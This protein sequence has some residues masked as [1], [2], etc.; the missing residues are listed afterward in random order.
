[1][2]TSRRPT[3]STSAPKRTATPVHQY[4]TKEIAKTEFI[5]GVALLMTETI[6]VEGFPHV[7]EKLAEIIN[8]LEII[9]GL[10]RASEVNATP[11]PG[12]TLVPAAEPLA[13]LR[14][15]YPIVYPRLIEILQ[16]LGASGLMA[17]PTECDVR[18]PLADAPERIQL[19]RLAWVIACSSFGSRQVLYERFFT[20]DRVRL[21]QARYQTYPRKD[22]L[23]DRARRFLAQSQPVQSAT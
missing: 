21:M 22:E 3:T 8:Y 9:R 12:G 23:K 19:F 7:Q 4:G 5:L 15:Y 17:I 13:A 20:G 6:A 16:L 11:G 18:G 2:A 14:N 1:M 10:V